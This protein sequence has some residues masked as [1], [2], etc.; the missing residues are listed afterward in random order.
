MAKRQ[1]RSTKE[2]KKPKQEKAKPPASLKYGANTS[3]PKGKGK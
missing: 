2:A 1:Q 3:A